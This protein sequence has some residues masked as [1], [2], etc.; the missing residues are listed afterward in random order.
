MKSNY[1]K[2]AGIADE[3]ASARVGWIKRQFDRYETYWGPPLERQIRNARMYWHVDF[4]QWPMQ[5]VEKLRAQGRRPPTFPV[6]P[7]KIES[8]VGN[9]IANTF[10]IKLEPRSNEHTTLIYK[11]Q[12]IIASQKSL[13]DWDTAKILCLLDSFIMVGYERMRVTDLKNPYGD[14]AFENLNPRHTYLDPGWKSNYNRDLKSYFVWD[15]LSIAE[16]IAL[17]GKSGERIRELELRERQEGIDY[18][19]CMGA[20]PRWRSID[21]KWSSKHRVYEF[22]HIQENTRFWEYDKKNGVWF[23]DNKF[24]PNSE[25]DKFSKLTYAQQMGLGPDDICMLKQ[26]KRTKFIE[27]ICPDMDKELFLDK[28]KDIIQ[29]DTV[30]LYPLG[31]RYYGQYQGITDRMY[32]LQVGINKG[33]MVIQDIQMRAAK[34]AFLLDRALTGG[35]PELERAIENAWNDPA[36]RIWVDEFATERLPKGGI[37]QLPGVTPTPDMFQQPARYYDLCDRFSKVPAAQDARTEST[38]ESGKLF[39]FKFEAG[40]I[41]QKFLMRFYEQH[42]RDKIEGVIKQ[43]KIT[44]AGVPRQF[45]LPGSKE[46]ININQEAVDLLSGRKVVLDDISALPEISVILVPAKTSVSIRDDIKQTS[47][48]LMQRTQDPLVQLV[49]QKQ[50]AL[51]S[52]LASDDG[53]KKEVEYAFDLSIQE[54][55]LTKMANIL[56]AK[57]N[58]AKLQ[59]QL[60]AQAQ[61]AAMAGGGGALP[62]GEGQ[63][64]DEEKPP[65]QQMTIQPPEAEGLELEAEAEEGTP[66]E[67]AA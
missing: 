26:K 4:G 61:Q 66:Q 27:V 6:V 20:V 44:F 9:F 1:I 13:M 10:D 15:D 37:V 25:E 47:G 28:G 52:E 45:T 63:A 23:P 40:I 54:Q 5:A 8:L 33:E 38:T 34:G 53:T 57:A 42:E 41:Q 29:T 16:I 31:I 59:A 46:T 43:A 21:E 2:Y 35:D 48:E 64:E 3:A 18:G 11:M 22:H 49:L 55:A 24:K 17:Y 50:I 58:I 67:K 14:I 39:K 65:T 36:A 12:D 32:D 56:N 62:P 19:I 60:Q 7:D 30:N 51:S